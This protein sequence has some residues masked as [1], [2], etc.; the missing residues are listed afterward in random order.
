MPFDINIGKEEEVKNISIRI[1]PTEKIIDSVSGIISYWDIEND[2]ILYY[3]DTKLNLNQKWS[4]TNIEEGDLV[5]IKNKKSN[6]ILPR[7]IWSSRIENEIEK[8]RDNNIEIIEVN[9][10]K[11]TFSCKLKMI[12][13]PGPINIGSK[14]ALSFDHVIH[15]DVPRSYPY[16][17]PRLEWRSEIFHPNIKPPEKGGRIW[18]EY[19]ENWHFSK[20]LI[21]LI[22]EIKN[23]LLNPDIKRRWKIRQCIEAYDVYISSGFPDSKN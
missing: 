13:T 8:L 20:S 17:K 10:S 12:D 1:D 18:I 9:F 3:K 4:E 7:D 6:K 16:E 21:T 22:Q 23:L 15:I 14:I 5:L 11:K 2:I 19:L